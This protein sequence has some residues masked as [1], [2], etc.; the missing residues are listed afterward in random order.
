[1]GLGRRKPRFCNGL[2]GALSPDIRWTG[3]LQ[4]LLGDD[5]T[6]IEEGLCG[7]NTN[8]DNSHQMGS[9]SSNGKTYLAPC[10]LSH[11]R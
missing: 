8:I 6:V 2:Y 10:L 1:M 5:Y 7:R 4:K 9:C 11:A 3:C